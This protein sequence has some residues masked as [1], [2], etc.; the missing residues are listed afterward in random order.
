[1]E[2]QRD[3]QAMGY[4]ETPEGG[5]LVSTGVDGG[6][7]GLGLDGVAVI[8]DPHKNRKE[9]ESR[10]IRDNIWDWFTDTF[11]SRLEDECSVL[12]IQTRWHKDDL[13]GRVLKGFEDPETGERIQFEEISKEQE[14]MLRAVGKFI[15]GLQNRSGAEDAADAPELLRVNA[16]VSANAATNKPASNITRTR[17]F[18]I[19]V[20]FSS[21]LLADRSPGF[22]S[23]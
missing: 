19:W 17:Y 20:M 15:S 1:M 14:A 13:A 2:L 11:W 5:S 18:K 3:S 21:S 22:T 12:I 16:V 7:T 4:F 6:V 23:R 9:A 10:L 8:D